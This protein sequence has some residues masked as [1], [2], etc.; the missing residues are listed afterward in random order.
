VISLSGTGINL[1]LTGVVKEIYAF[2]L[3]SYTSIKKFLFRAQ[4]LYSFKS[5]TCSVI[6]EGFLLNFNSIYLFI[7][8][9]SYRM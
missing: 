5:E 2:I 9:L 3:F 4:N 7:K 1:P 8:H 6:A